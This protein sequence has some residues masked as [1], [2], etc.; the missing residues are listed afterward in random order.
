MHSSTSD[1][2]TYP[3]FWGKKEKGY[4]RSSIVGALRRSAAHRCL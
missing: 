4:Q 3:G 2:N 1:K